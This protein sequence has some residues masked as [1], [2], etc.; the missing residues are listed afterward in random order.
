MALNPQKSAGK[1]SPDGL[2][3]RSTGV[4]RRTAAE[5]SSGR[6][7]QLARLQHCKFLKTSRFPAN[8]RL[9][10]GQIDSYHIDPS[11]ELM[12]QMRKQQ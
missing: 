6:D 9:V 11:Y 3:A 5:S 10:S 7:D 2:V 1:G 4:T 8:S 12:S